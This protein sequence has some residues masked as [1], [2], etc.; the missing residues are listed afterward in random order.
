MVMKGKPRGGRRCGRKA[1]Y[2]SDWKKAVV[3]L[4]AGRQDR[5]VRGSVGVPIK[6]FKPTSAGR[7][8]ASGYTFS[9]ITKST[10]EKSLTVSKKQARPAATTAA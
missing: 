4:A 3:T 2:G 7:R 9:E 8:G 5:A 1:T 6:Q 10:P